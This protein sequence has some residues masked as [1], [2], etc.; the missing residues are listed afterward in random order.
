[1]VKAIVFDMDGVLFDTEILCLNAWQKVADKYN[2]G[3]ITTA[4][5]SC[6]GVS[7]EKSKEIF[8]TA[9]SKDFPYDEMR[10][11]VSDLC[12]QEISKN[13]LVKKKGVDE[14]LSFCKKSGIKIGLATSTRRQTV[15]SHLER[16]E[17]IDFFDEIICGDEI[18]NSKPSPEIYLKSCK[19][20]GIEPQNALAIEDSYNGVKASNSAG[21]RCIMVPDILPPTDEIKSLAFTVKND[22][23]EVIEFL[24]TENL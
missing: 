22:L 1:M 10:N 24:K 20:L 23:F 12:H 9:M 14:I 15:I 13:G 16:T 5:I 8:K 17:I 11:K 7:K 6:I 18:E 19:K 4:C 3:N 21:V 2:L